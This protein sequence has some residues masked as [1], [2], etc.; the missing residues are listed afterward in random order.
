MK[1]NKAKSHK[2]REVLK[3]IKPTRIKEVEN[4]KHLFKK[5]RNPIVYEK[6]HDRLFT[7]EES[8]VGHKHIIRCPMSFLL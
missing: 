4:M 6:I 7:E 3:Y 5:S 2:L 1:E 8:L